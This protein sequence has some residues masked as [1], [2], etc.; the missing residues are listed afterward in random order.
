MPSASAAL[1]VSPTPPP[2]GRRRHFISCS[3]SNPRPY[4]RLISSWLGW[5]AAAMPA[6]FSL[7]A[8]PSSMP[9]SYAQPK[10]M[11]F[12]NFRVRA[13]S[14]SMMIIRKSNERG[15]AE[16]GWL[17]SYHTFSFADYYDPQWAGFR[18]LRV[19]N[20]DLV[21]PGMGFGAHPHRDMEIISYVLGG[22]LQ[23]RD[24]MGNG[25]VIRP[26]NFNIFPPAPAW[27]T[28]SLTP[29]APRPRAFCR[30]GS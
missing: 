11:V 13:H 18:A 1:S 2:P 4:G 25:R 26:A 22:A 5:A 3:C 17:D 15:H 19:I 9:E 20:D 29:P 27:S 6:A 24:S 16:H 23:H 12:P 14:G 7:Y 10:N 21:M 8:C 30:S 28:A